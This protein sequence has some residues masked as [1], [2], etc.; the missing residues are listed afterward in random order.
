MV[1]ST[2]ASPRW[3]T[4]PPTGSVPA[5]WHSFC[6][7]AL[8]SDKRAVFVLLRH[9]RKVFYRMGLNDEEIVA[10]SGAHTLG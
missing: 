1:A 3:R 6:E 2:V 7:I 10:L 8:G 4:P 5:C 9:L